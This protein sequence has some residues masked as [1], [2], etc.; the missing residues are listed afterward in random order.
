VL[1]GEVPNGTPN[2]LMPYITQVGK[3]KLEK[4]N[5]FGKNYDTKD[6]SCVRDYIHV[7]DLA[8]GHVDVLLKMK[9]GLS[10]YNLGTGIGTSVLELIEAFEK[11]NSVPIPYNITSRREGDIAVSYADVSKV[12]N[13]IGWKSKLLINDMVRDAWNF[14]INSNKNKYL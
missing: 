8:E 1:I 6:G 2:N 3:K 13:E 9:K 7:V 4:L 5:V 12:G 10:I 14:E 11:V